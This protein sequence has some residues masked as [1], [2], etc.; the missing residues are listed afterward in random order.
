MCSGQRETVRDHVDKRSWNKAVKL[1]PESTS[2]S[3]IVAIF[4]V[5]RYF[6]LQRGEVQ[7]KTSGKREHLLNPDVDGMFLKE[8]SDRLWNE[9][10][11]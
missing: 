9:L 1:L 7:E 3:S 8:Q 5:P 10:T 4:T 6:D 11:F 2:P